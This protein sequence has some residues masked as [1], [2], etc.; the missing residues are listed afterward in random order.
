M[1]KKLFALILSGALFVLD[2]S[3]FAADAKSSGLRMASD[4]APPKGSEAIA[5]KGSSLRI[6]VVN[7]KKCV[8]QSK[9]GKQEQSSFEAMKKQME[10]VLAEKE[11]SL[12]GF[13]YRLHF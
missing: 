12:N 9:Q 13:S 8:E 3:V 10:S 7:F 4:V 11:K 5:A 6:A 2:P 1:K